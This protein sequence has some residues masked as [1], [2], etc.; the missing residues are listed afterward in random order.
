MADHDSGLGNLSRN[1]LRDI[2]VKLS[3]RQLQMWVQSLGER[4]GFIVYLTI[5]G[6][7]GRAKAMGVGWCGPCFLS[8]HGRNCHSWPFRSSWSSLFICPSWPYQRLGLA[9]WVGPPLLSLIL[10]LGPLG[11]P[12][13]LQKPKRTC[14][15]SQVLFELLVTSYR[16]TSHWSKQVTWPNPKSRGSH[17]I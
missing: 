2:Q 1:D 5:I 15:I 14:P 3:N 11:W 13:C 9:G 10:L 8:P 16:S 12:G 6:R 4:T 7:R 17:S